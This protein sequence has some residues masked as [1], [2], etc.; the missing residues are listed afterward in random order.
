MGRIA[1][2]ADA[3]ADAAELLPE[4]GAKGIGIVAADELGVLVAVLMEDV[5]HA[6]H[7]GVEE[8]FVGDVLEGVR[9]NLA[10]RVG[11]VAGEGVLL[12]AE[13]AG[14][15]DG[16]GDGE[17]QEVALGHSANLAGIGKDVYVWGSA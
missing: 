7:G 11:G 2:K 17:D 16:E 1:A 13:I 3:D 9:A 6:A 5:D 15:G 10:Q 14:V 4:L 8:L 12:A